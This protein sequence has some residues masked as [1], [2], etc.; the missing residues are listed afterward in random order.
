MAISLL[1]MKSS[2]D[3]QLFFNFSDGQMSDLEISPPPR[4]KRN[5]MPR[6]S[7]ENSQSSSHDKIVKRQQVNSNYSDVVLTKKPPN[8][9]TTPSTGCET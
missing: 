9:I 1:K 5:S 4:N 6:K 8:V 7:N 3:L 2:L